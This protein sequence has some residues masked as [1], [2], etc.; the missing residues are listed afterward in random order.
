M[1]TALITGGSAGIGKVT[2]KALAAKGYK[3]I[4]AARD[5][6]KGDALVNAINKE[7]PEC[8]ARFYSVDMSKFNDVRQ[9]AQ[10]IRDNENEIDLLM[11]NAGL[12]TNPLRES[13]SK[14]EFMF[15]TTHLGHF[16]LTHELLP[17]VKKADKARVVVT[18]S[19]AHRIGS[20]IDFFDAL[21]HLPKKR[22]GLLWAFKNYGRSKLANLLFVREL[23]ERLKDEGILVN[24][25]H[26]GSVKTE[27]W[28]GT[29][30]LLNIISNPFLISEEKGADTQ[31]FLATDP[32]LDIT[33][34]YWCRRNIDKSTTKSKNPQLIKELWEYSEKALDIENFGIPV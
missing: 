20:K 8:E 13:E 7:H 25:F 27:I 4:I 9:F 31:I 14:H 3:V 16:L 28:R 15:A 34:E 17:L 21:K 10:T 18:S 24:A 12:F 26:P 2:S 29:P 6:Q 1:K 33:G 11:L 32:G 19:V 22:G 5:K 30:S 23:A